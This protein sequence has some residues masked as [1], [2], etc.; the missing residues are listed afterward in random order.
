MKKVRLIFISHENEQ[1]VSPGKELCTMLTR[2]QSN[3]NHSSKFYFN[4]SHWKEAKLID[5]LNGSVTPV[6]FVEHI[7]CVE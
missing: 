5:S 1:N 6:V 4:T 2:I 7:L 3:V